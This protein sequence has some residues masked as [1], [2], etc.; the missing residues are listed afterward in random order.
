LDE[1]E[2]LWKKAVKT[3]GVARYFGAGASG[4]NGRPR[5]KLRTLKNHNYLLNLLLLCSII[6]IFVKRKNI[7]FSFKIFTWPPP[8]ASYAIGDALTEGTQLWWQLP[9]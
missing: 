9:Q 7:F 1:L 3:S 4:N 2:R 8:P 6:Q 5:Q